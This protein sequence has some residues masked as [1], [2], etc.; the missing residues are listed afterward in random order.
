MW[1]TT[2]GS[3]LTPSRVRNIAQNCTVLKPNVSRFFISSGSCLV[4]L[5]RPFSRVHALLAWSFSNVP[6]R[7]GFKVLSRANIRY[8]IVTTLFDTALWADTICT[9]PFLAFYLKNGL[10]VT[11]LTKIR[12]RYGSNLCA[13]LDI[14]R[15]THPNRCGDPIRYDAV[16]PVSAP[17]PCLLSPLDLPH[18][19]GFVSNAKIAFVV[20]KSPVFINLSFRLHL[21]Y[22]FECLFNRRL[23]QVIVFFIK[24][25]PL[26]C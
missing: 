14:A 10:L 8:F 22:I 5:W 20:V 25:F 19:I 6:F 13:G 21:I 11:T 2:L 15:C 24:G 4:S 3:M 16:M 12:R 7:F 18:P 17:A 1:R 26:L 9:Q 23:V